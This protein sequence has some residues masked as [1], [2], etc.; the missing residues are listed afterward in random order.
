MRARRDNRFLLRHAIN[1]DVKE[2][3]HACADQERH[4]RKEPGKGGRDFGERSAE[5]EEGRCDFRGRRSAL[6][7]TS[8]AAAAAAAERRTLNVELPT[9]N[10]EP[11]TYVCRG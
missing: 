1:D 4:D 7:G 9:L 11:A 6:Q 5:H 10:S 2:A 8:A 3:A